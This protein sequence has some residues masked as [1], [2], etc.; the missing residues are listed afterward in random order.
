MEQI[1][2]T[3]RKKSSYTG[4]NAVGISPANYRCIR[5]IAEECELRMSDVANALIT[6]ALDHIKF[7]EAKS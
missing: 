1:V 3:K 7:E 6:F 5:D 2:F 4:G